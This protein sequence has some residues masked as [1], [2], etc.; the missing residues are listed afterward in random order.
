MKRKYSTEMMNLSTQSWPLLLQIRLLLLLCALTFALILPGCSKKAPEQPSTLTVSALLPL[1]GAAASYGQNALE[2]AQLALAEFN[3]NAKNK[4]LPTVNLAVE[5]SKGDPKD[6]VAA[7]QKLITLNHIQ[8]VVGDVTSSATLAIA[9]IANANNVVVISPAA[10]APAIS[11]AGDYI[12]RTW[13][14]DTFEAS[15][16]ADYINKGAFP[17][18]AFLYVN[19]DYGQAITNYLRQH[20]RKGIEIVAAETFLPSASNVRDQLAK[21]AA[22]SPSAIFFV[23]Y[24]KDTVTFLRQYGEMGMM[25]PLISVSAFE[26]TSVLKEVHKQAE[27][28]VYSSPILS[29][30]ETTTKFKEAYKNKYRKDAGLVADTGY[31][32]MKA[33]LLAYER[34]KDPSGRALK[35]NL[36]GLVFDG[37]SGRIHFDEKG[38]VLKPAGLKTVRNG[39]FEW[40][41]K[42]P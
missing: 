40:L 30:S 14:P 18:L 10:S 24:P 35:H 12:Y 1:T 5:D 6:A 3:A 31:D 37:A 7:M 38:D 28:V 26:D 34:A 42:I 21:I 16:V 33:I 19:N 15:V 13:P 4:G 8:A 20:L 32:A 9:P 25:M 36:D 22:S 41:E 29:E 11:D 2:G 27:G 17:R 39:A 23:S